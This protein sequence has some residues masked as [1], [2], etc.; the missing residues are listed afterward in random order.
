MKKILNIIVITTLFLLLANSNVFAWSIDITPAYGDQ[1]DTDITAQSGDTVYYQVWFNADP[2]GNLMEAWTG[3]TMRFLMDTDE[4]NFDLA[5]STVYPQG[6]I[7][8]SELKEDP[9]DYV[10]WG[11]MNL[12]MDYSFT[13]SVLLADL[14]F[15]VIDPLNDDL[16]DLIYDDTVHPTGDGWQLDGV[17]YDAQTIVANHHLTDGA[18]VAP[19]PIPGAA[20]LLGSGLLGMIGLRRRNQE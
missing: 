8:I 10:T 2:G 12:F 3:A 5:N 15:T 9:T 16:P 18:D 1:D 7:T 19:V 20:L 11:Y 6:T 17:W 14:A 4:I 13:D